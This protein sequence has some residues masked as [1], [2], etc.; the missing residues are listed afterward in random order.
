MGQLKLCWPEG[1]DTTLMSNVSQ[2]FFGVNDK[3]TAQYVSDRLGEATIVVESGG[4]SRSTTMQSSQEGKGSASHSTSRNDNWSQLA[5]RL[6]KPEEVSALNPREAITF[7]PGVPPI[8]TWLVRYFEKDFTRFRRIGL[9]KAFVDATCLLMCAVIVAVM[10][11]V[12]FQSN[13]FAR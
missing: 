10:F 5:R 1:R 3:E 12:A 6:L 13:T 7:T 2:V 11:T 9:V 8:S 4:T